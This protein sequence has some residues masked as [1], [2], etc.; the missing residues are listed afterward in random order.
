MMGTNPSLDLAAMSEMTS[1]EGTSR[2]LAERK[3]A[4][5]QSIRARRASLSP[6]ARA[7]ATAGL[8][9]QL[10]A[11]VAARDARTIA[12]FLS[13]ETEPETRPFIDWALDAGLTVLLPIS[14]EDGLLDWAHADAAVDA[15]T[16]RHGI[17]EPAGDRLGVPALGEVDLAIVPASAVDRTGTR[18]GWGMGYYDKS[19]ATLT[20]TPPLFALVYDE[21]VV[22]SLPRE[23][24]DVPATGVVTPTITIT[25]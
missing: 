12:C 6:D 22:D 4:L 10:R 21:E 7:A 16:G 1:F 25:F 24:H 14:R 23:T 2:K 18:M 19:L 11:L 13:T 15:V 3:R 8:T 9:E 20:V 17:P 5:R